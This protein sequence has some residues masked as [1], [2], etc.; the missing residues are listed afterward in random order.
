MTRCTAIWAFAI[1]VGLPICAASAGII[2]DGVVSPF[3][4]WTATNPGGVGDVND[5]DITDD[6]VDIEHVYISDG[7]DPDNLYF[8]WDFWDGPPRYT[9]SGGYVE[10]GFVLYLNGGANVLYATNRPYNG[11][12]TLDGTT[13]YLEDMT[14]T[15]AS[16]GTYA[17]GVGTSKTVEAYIP[18]AAFADL[19]ITSPVPGTAIDFWAYIVEQT[20]QHDDLTDVGSYTV[21]VPEPATM[22]LLAV[23]LGGLAGCF[24]R[25]RKG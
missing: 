10:Y 8:R 3:D 5:L 20:A 24:R 2:A 9:T 6:K 19:G 1:A 21:F 16:T 12:G 17:V 18:Y 23:G 13:F 25:R 11:G 22:T 4:E 15:A 14:S 7:G